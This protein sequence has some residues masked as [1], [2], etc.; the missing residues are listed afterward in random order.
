MG[1][2]RLLERNG[3][4]SGEVPREGLAVWGV[5]AASLHD[6]VFSIPNL[7]TSES[8]IALKLV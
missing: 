7:V 4:G 8:T 1:P 6:S 5:V 2:S 3:R